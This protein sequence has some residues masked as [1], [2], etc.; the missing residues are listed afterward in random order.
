MSLMSHSPLKANIYT[1]ITMP[2]TS[3]V[4]KHPNVQYYVNYSYVLQF[5]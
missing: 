2:M 3:I 4:P 5:L 1:S